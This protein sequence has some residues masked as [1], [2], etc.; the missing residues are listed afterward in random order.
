VDHDGGLLVTEAARR[1]IMTVATL[2]GRTGDFDREAAVALLGEIGGGS[3]VL[4]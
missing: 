1:W 4:T 3:T 2:M